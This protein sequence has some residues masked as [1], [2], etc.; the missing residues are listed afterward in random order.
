M[1]PPFEKSGLAEIVR[2]GKCQCQKGRATP[3]PSRRWPFV[4]SDP[5]VTY[6]VGSGARQMRLHCP[7]EVCRICNRRDIVGE[8]DDMKRLSWSRPQPHLLTAPVSS[9]GLR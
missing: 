5:R 4:A 2:P 7:F 3:K 6:H 9:A 8:V 1:H